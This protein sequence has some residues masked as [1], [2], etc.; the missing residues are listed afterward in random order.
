MKRFT[1]R[2][3][4]SP[5]GLNRSSLAR[6]KDYYTRVIRRDIKAQEKMAKPA[7]VNK[8]KTFLPPIIK[9]SVEPSDYDMP[10]I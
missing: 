10:V 4:V 3:S 7:F 8:G 2:S 1:S 6:A 9:T 5:D